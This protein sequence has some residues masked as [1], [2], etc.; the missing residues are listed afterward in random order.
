M[1]HYFETE[2][3]FKL[4]H[5]S[6]V[7]EQNYAENKDLNLEKKHMTFFKKCSKL[8]FRLKFYFSTNFCL[9]GPNLAP[10]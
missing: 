4:K 5:K 6:F 1:K 3:S 7:T 8:I 10:Q 2:K 9:Y